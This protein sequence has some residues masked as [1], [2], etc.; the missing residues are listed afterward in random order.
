MKK[1]IE[2]RYWNSNGFAVAIVA[3]ITEGIDW[4]AYIGAT[5][6]SK[7]EQETVEYVAKYGCKL[8]SKDAKYYFPF[9]NLRYRE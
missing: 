7:T 2:G 9:I 3:V 5:D 1:I 4:A 8:S 6:D